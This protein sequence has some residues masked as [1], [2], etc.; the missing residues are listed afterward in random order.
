M[1]ANIEIPGRSRRTLIW[2]ALTLLCNQNF[3]TADD[4]KVEFRLSD[5]R[6]PPVKA[7]PAEAGKIVVTALP[8]SSAV[9]ADLPAPPAYPLYAAQEGLVFAAIGSNTSIAT[10]GHNEIVPTY[11]NLS[12]KK[13]VP[14]VELK[15]LL[16]SAAA[17]HNQV[18]NSDT[19]N[20]N[21]ANAGNSV[22]QNASPFTATSL[23]P[24]ARLQEPANAMASGVKTY[25]V[26]DMTGPLADQA[27][28]LSGLTAPS[29]YQNAVLV[30]SMQSRMNIGEAGVFP[31]NNSS[32]AWAA[33]GFYHN[34]LY[35]EQEN[36]ERYGTGAPRWAQPTL[37][38]A[39]FFATIPLLP[40]KIGSQGICENV[41]TLGHY[42]PGD[43]TPHQ[44][45]WGPF[46]WRGVGY[47]A[48][49]T[50]GLIFALP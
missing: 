20:L 30:D 5:N 19:S 47:Q 31:W 14:Q 33:T 27:T 32:Y 1:L 8:S 6:T 24:L 3:L 21:Q 34:P 13:M 12:L 48:M 37:S 35:F 7:A 40:Y 23:I 22:V 45:H 11:A 38:A 28:L 44:L 25:S 4:P 39:H 46:S 50:T 17:E 36:L 10:I 49:T 9:P 42:R 18:A 15:P 2:I 26:A 41:Y 16:P 43:C 29:P